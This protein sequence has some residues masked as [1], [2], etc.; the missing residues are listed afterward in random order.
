MDECLV[1]INNHPMS[2]VVSLY[3]MMCNAVFTEEHV[4]NDDDGDDDDV[5]QYCLLQRSL[6]MILGK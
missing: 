1:I 4:Y 6:Y 3:I 2:M 5:P